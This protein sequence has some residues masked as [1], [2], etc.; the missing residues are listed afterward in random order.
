MARQLIFT[1]AP[2]GLEPG[3]SGYC[4]V[5]RHKDIRS[6]LVRELERLSVYDY[7]QQGDGPKA[8]VALFRKLALG[9]EEF[10]V[11]S[12]I[13]DAGLDYT[14]RTNYIAHH[15]ILDSFEIATVP[16]PAEILTN[17]NG[18]K[19]KWEEGPRYLED[20]EEVDLTPFKSPALIPADGWL[21]ATNDPGNAAI[22]VSPSMKKPV[23]LEVDPGQEES[24]LQ[25]FAESSALHKLSLDAWDYSF[26][27]FLQ[28]NDDAK[29]F[30]WIGAR[31][32]PAAERLKQGGAPN[33][34]DLR[35]FAQSKVVDPIDDDL[36]HVAR[37]GPKAKASGAKSPKTRAKAPKA[38]SDR[39][40]AQFQQA[41][42]SYTASAAPSGSTVS[43]QDGSST[44]KKRKRRP[45]LMQLAV[46]STALCLLVGLVVGLAYNLG[47]FLNKNGDEPDPDNPPIVSPVPD[48]I[49]ESPSGEP[50][51]EGA[52][53]MVGKPGVVVL[54][55][56]DEFLDW[57]KFDVG[58]PDPIT[59]DLNRQQ[60]KI[61]RDFLGTL[62]PDD[63][64]QVTLVQRDGELTIETL[65]EVRELQL[66]GEP[67]EEN[68][69]GEH[70]V[71]L[72]GNIV[73]F[74]IP[75]KGELT[76]ELPSDRP[77]LREQIERL[78]V[79]LNENPSMGVPLKLRLEEG[80]I[81]GIDSITIPQVDIDPVP[82]FRPE[83]TGESRVVLLDAPNAAT[84]LPDQRIVEINVD[85]VRRLPYTFR[86]DEEKRIRDL[87]AYLEKGGKGL[88]LN[89]RVDGNKITALEFTIPAAAVSVV[90]V[91]PDPSGPL[92]R[93]PESAYVL[94]LPAKTLPGKPVRWQL[95]LPSSGSVKYEQPSFS[96][97]FDA[98]MRAFIGVEQAHVWQ[99]DFHGPQSFYN[100]ADA[101]DDFEAFAVEVEPDRVDPE[102][103]ARFSLKTLGTGRSIYSL[104]FNVKRG[105]SVEIDF[106]ADMAKNAADRGF[107][108]RIPK[109][110]DSCMDL[111]FVS[112]KHFVA[113]LGYPPVPRG[114]QL[115][116]SGSTL[117]F[118]PSWPYGQNF[119]V[120][121]KGKGGSHSLGVAPASGAGGTPRP[122]VFFSPSMPSTTAFVMGYVQGFPKALV[123]PKQ[124]SL[125]VSE[126]MMNVEY[127]AS[128]GG[129]FQS[130]IAK[131]DAEMKRLSATL[132][133]PQVY[134][135]LRMFGR[136]AAKS[137]DYSLGSS[138]GQY[139]LEVTTKF[140]QQAFGWDDPQTIMFR[141]K[142]IGLSDPQ[143]FHA[144][145]QALGQF[146]QTAASKLKEEAERHMDG[147][148]YNAERADHDVD[149]A[150]RLVNF[151][152]HV[153]RTFGM[154]DTSL[155]VQLQQIRDSFDSPEPDKGLLGKLRKEIL[156][157]GEQ[158]K[159]TAV[160]Q[161]FTKFNKAYLDPASQPT[162][163][164]KL[165]WQEYSKA[166]KLMS[167]A[168]SVAR[169]SQE[170]AKL[171]QY[172]QWLKR[173]NAKFIELKAARD[174]AFR[175]GGSQIQQ[176]RERL[177]TEKWALALFK[178]NP[179][180]ARQPATWDRVSDLVTF[181]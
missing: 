63:Q 7:N 160:G 2:Q 168:A 145:E 138:Y 135:N 123:I 20:S 32:Q 125:P 65:G 118:L 53:L 73:T 101:A 162:P 77:E 172:D 86:A 169:F 18:W 113:E 78:V 139:L 76:Y 72:D 177:V 142:L 59:V 108:L 49:P 38:F 174:A 19:T 90:P 157:M 140:A 94:W 84:I 147:F 112:N 8:K 105:V 88:K 82:P 178:I 22:L 61:Y 36:A 116:L 129:S 134:D 98:L 110:T 66:M 127:F 126:I 156:R 48:I 167:D 40:M 128:L 58:S 143:S 103:Q 29:I 130:E 35:D 17:W 170:R 114:E 158:P 179:P 119:H 71:S 121:T 181:R 131:Y 64:L 31:G 120:L 79:A 173:M 56:K 16:S 159:G 42:S 41:A 117:R 144:N 175:A 9:S 171:S 164:G 70:A 100:L 3:R 37:K 4:T 102:S 24:L 107:V 6:R 54:R 91:G 69:S 26:T 33:Y 21:A 148:G 50:V 137:T 68:I 39:E 23:L 163:S 89:A 52:T 154:K 92:V 51:V 141:K 109:G 122:D 13:S 155:A 25:L 46:I 30:S 150:F 97:L 83:P 28:E 166:L 146:W 80:R 14:N 152:M 15:L 60:R 45:W 67:F 161:K 57:V 111:Y 136:N 180:A 151:F 87:V 95:D 5:A 44:G 149:V 27:T 124:G 81:V 115:K 96:S 10:F 133:N 93:T 55:E 47:D 1:S 62:G 85:G 165:V 153:E 34:L 104:E 11:L 176:A 132:P 12:R 74:N 99:T 106:S 75:T 43:A